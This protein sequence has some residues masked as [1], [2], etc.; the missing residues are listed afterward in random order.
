[1][2]TEN[3]DYNINRAMKYAGAGAGG[4]DCLVA[5]AGNFCEKWGG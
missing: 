5:Q 4:G 3:K 1:M 2:L